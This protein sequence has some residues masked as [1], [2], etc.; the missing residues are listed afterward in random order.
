MNWIR[1][2]GLVLLC[3]FFSACSEEQSE[4]PSSPKTTFS[5]PVISGFS[6]DPSITRVGDDFYLVNST[7]EYFPALPIYHSRDL[8]NWEL[9]SHAVSEPGYINLA[10]ISSSGG[11]HAATIRYHKGLFYVVTTNMVEGKPI[12]FI[13]TADDPRGPWSKP[14]IVKESIGIDPS[15]FFDDDGR[16][17]YT[18]NWVPPEQEFPGQALVWIQELDPETFQLIGER[19]FLWSGC[20]KGVWAEGPHIYKKDGIYYL[21]LSEGGTSYE[22][23]ISMASSTS[24]TGPYEGTP[25][26][27][28]LTHR[29]LSFD[30]PITGVGH[31][32]L[33][34]LADG[35]WV[36]VALAWRLI[37]GEHGILGRET[38]LFPVTW[39][40]E[41][42]WWKE[43]KKTF[44]VM[45]PE[46]GRVE[47][48]HD[49]PFPGIVQL[50]HDKFI[51]EFDGKALKLE[52]NTRRSHEA[53]FHELDLKQ[54]LLKLH[55]QPSFIKER[56]Q[57]AFL[58]VRQRNFQF[59][60]ET[61]MVFAPAN[62]AEEAGIALILNDHAAITLTRRRSD[63]GDEVALSKWHHGERTKLA[64]LPVK[65]SK[66]KLRM[67]GDYLSYRFYVAE[68]GNDW[69]V[70]GDPVDITFM[71]PA[72]LTGFNYTGLYLGLYASSN[73]AES[74]NHASYASFAVQ[75]L[76]DRNHWY[77]RNQP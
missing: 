14:V 74:N 73:G 26:N 40:T 69:Q 56:E 12:S 24:V 50:D 4:K 64:S 32:D 6:P 34:E 43:N 63:Q 30:H 33:V 9:I 19:T 13:V 62:N 37:D 16:V 46:T 41:R 71:S 27:P 31:A 72:V 11:V 53:P 18:A 48:N 10:S 5:N 76:G 61:E 47:L 75:A 57:Y 21:L 23:A 49:L 51:D 54:G 15:L 39:E 42:E 22:H 25:R 65:G 60:S 52:W 28:V 38:F 2:V 55:L 20:C 58:G 59:T 66:L 36:G 35:R 68:N 17:W 7:F 8:V 29:H 44:P 77:I 45:S 70:L 3:L 1:T 67:E